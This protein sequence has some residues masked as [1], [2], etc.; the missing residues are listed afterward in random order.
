MA[1]I[2][3]A[4]THV[5]IGGR[6]LSPGDKFSAENDYADKLIESKSAKLF[7]ESK[8]KQSEVTGLER[9]TAKELLEWSE[10]NEIEIK[11]TDKKD[12]INELTKAGVKEIENI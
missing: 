4:I 8:T 5:M 7:K 11:S 10:K 6:I 9:F 3:V 12:I 2:L 1:K